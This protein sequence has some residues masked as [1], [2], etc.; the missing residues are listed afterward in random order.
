MFPTRVD[1]HFSLPAIPTVTALITGTR[2]RAH[3]GIPKW[4]RRHRIRQTGT[5]VRNWDFLR[6]FQVGQFT[7]YQ[8]KDPIWTL[9]ENALDRAPR[10]LLVSFQLRKRLGPVLHHFIGA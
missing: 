8:N 9:R 4:S 3:R 5:H 10:P 7:T 2:H 6:P 1:T